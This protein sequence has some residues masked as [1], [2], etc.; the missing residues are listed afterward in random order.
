MDKTP[1]TRRRIIQEE[2]IKKQKKLG[3]LATAFTIFKGFVASGILYLPKDFVNGGYGFSAICILAALCLTIYCTVLLIEVH[4]KV[5]G[6]LPDIGQKV[7]GKAGKIMV[8]IS[9]FGSQFGFVCAYI[10][11]IASQV[12]GPNG[13]I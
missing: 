8:D 5:G 11:F 9:L 6:S 2:T 3:P 1:Q 4:A 12:G 10:Y 7:Y 13:I